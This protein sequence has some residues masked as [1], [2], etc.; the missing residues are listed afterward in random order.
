MLQFNPYF[1]PSAV[2]ILKN[3]LFED[4]RSDIRENSIKHLANYQVFLPV[5]SDDAFDYENNQNGKY[6][7]TE[8]KSLL[9]QEI[10]DFNKEIKGGPINH[11]FK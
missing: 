1:R 11:S 8:L 3:D 4:F 10:N 9:I 7:I 2:E 6:S 5:D